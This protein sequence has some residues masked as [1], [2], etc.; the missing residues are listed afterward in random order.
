MDYYYQVENGMIVVQVSEN[1]QLVWPANEDWYGSI[2]DCPYDCEND[3]QKQRRRL[4]DHIRKNQVLLVKCLE[5]A[6]K[7]GFPC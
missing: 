6:G 4:E 2:K 3:L 1:N 5:Q 7:L